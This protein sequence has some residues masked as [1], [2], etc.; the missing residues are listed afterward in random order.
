MHHAIGRHNRETVVNL[1]PKFNCQ[2]H[3]LSFVRK[4]QNTFNMVLINSEK[5]FEISDLMVL[6]VLWFDTVH[7]AFVKNTVQALT[8]FFVTKDKY[9]ER[10][11]TF[12]I[13]NRF[14]ID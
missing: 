13:R 1:E 7:D 11:G 8:T 5:R 6:T 4:S 10:N 9:T 14:L 12:S 2:K 3:L